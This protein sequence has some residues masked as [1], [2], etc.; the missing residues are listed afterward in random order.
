MKK[1][2]VVLIACLMALLGVAVGCLICFVWA[3]PY[4]PGGSAYM[5]NAVSDNEFAKLEEIQAYLDYYFVGDMDEQALLDGA[6]SGL[7]SGTGDRWS[8]YVSA[9]DMDAFL[10]GQNNA[11]VGVGITIQKGENENG[12]EVIKVTRNSPAQEAGVLPGDILHAVEG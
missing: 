10:E 12:F 7:I 8:Y 6:A 4:L 5:A 2:Y 1:K 9:E 3:R 11:Y